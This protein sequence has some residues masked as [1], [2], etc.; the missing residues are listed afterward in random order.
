MTK[1]AEQHEPTFNLE[2]LN[3][4][5]AQAVAEALSKKEQET[6]AN[7]SDDMAT[8]CIRA[9]PGRASKTFSPERT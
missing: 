1:Q 7:K 3:K 2:T 6:K 5:I 9:S 8:L 4:L